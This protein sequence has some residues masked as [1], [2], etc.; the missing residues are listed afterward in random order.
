[1]KNIRHAGAPMLAAMLAACATVPAEEPAAP[2]PQPMPSGQCSAQPGQVL[3][4]ETATA[5]LGTRALELTGATRL[6]WGPPG[7]VFT[8]DYREDRVNV[9]YDG[10]MMVTEVK[11]G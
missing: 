1:M 11:C 10:E 5:D 4:G 8:I 3:I 2:E 6:R 7:A 9:I